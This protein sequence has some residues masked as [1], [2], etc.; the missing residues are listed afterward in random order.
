[1][2]GQ[3]NT[4]RRCAASSARTCPVNSVFADIWL[5]PFVGDL[6][7]RPTRQCR[8]GAKVG[9]M[10]DARYCVLPGSPMA[11]I[12]LKPPLAHSSTFDELDERGHSTAFS[13]ARSRNQPECGRRLV[14]MSGLRAWHVDRTPRVDPAARRAAIRNI[15]AALRTRRICLTPFD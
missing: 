11:Q 3:A 4:R 13:E 6:G 12:R 9:C 8:D 15:Q 2:R 1:M 10:P 7:S 5:Y 14:R